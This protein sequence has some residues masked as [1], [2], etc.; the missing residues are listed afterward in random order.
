MDNEILVGFIDVINERVR[1]CC[2][3]WIRRPFWGDCRRIAG[4]LPAFLHSV[5]SWVS[6]TLMCRKRDLSQWFHRYVLLYG[7]VV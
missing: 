5:R 7:S 6:A 4:S 3:G 2:A 1:Y